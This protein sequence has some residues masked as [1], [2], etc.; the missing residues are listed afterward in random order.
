VIVHKAKDV[1]I[2]RRRG[3]LA[4]IF[5]SV[6]KNFRIVYA[7]EIGQSSVEVILARGEVEVGGVATVPTPVVRKVGWASN[8]K[9]NA[10]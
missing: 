8:E 2:R 3:P 9:I 4:E 10:S 7:N 6:S 1:Y 5:C